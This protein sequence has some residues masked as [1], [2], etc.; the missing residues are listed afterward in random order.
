[1]VGIRGAAI[2]R[3]FGID[4]RATRE[5]V[6][7]F[8]KD[9]HGGAFADN[10]TVAGFVKGPRGV[11]RGVVREGGEGAGTLES[12]EGKWVDARFRAAG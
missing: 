10:E 12:G 9:E 8:F 3:K 4:R 6:C 5:S 11:L 7:E 2:A 1:M